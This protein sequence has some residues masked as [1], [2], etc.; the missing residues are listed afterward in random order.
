[1]D[2][3]AR[4]HYIKHGIHHFYVIGWHHHA[5]P[6]ITPLEKRTFFCRIVVVSSTDHFRGKINWDDV[7][8]TMTSKTLPYDP[9]EA[10][11]QSKL[12]N[13]MHA[14]QLTN[15]LEGSGVSVFAVHPGRTNKP[16]AV[17]TCQKFLIS[18]QN[19]CVLLLSSWLFFKDWFWPKNSVSSRFWHEI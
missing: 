17:M 14:N 10:Y 6:Y 18:R 1:M 16:K 11:Y 15:R 5:Y 4:E 7:N 19:I 12:A 13:M 8:F 2:L 3:F 9:A